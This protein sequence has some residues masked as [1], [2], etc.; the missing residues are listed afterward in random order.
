M[1]E[2]SPNHGQMTIIELQAIDPSPYQLRK[3]FDEDKLKE[4]AASILRDG[5]IEPIVVRP[6][7]ER[8]Q[9]K[10]LSAIET[11]EAIVEIV[12]AELIED[13]EYLSMGDKPAD[14]VKKLLGKIDSVRRSR[15]RGFNPAKETKQAS[16]RFAGRVEDLFNNLPKPLEWRTFYRHDLPLP[17]DFCEEVREVS[18]R[19]RLN[20][21]QTRALEKLRSASIQEFQRVTADAQR[22]APSPVFF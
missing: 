21:S 2:E 22:P 13:K 8:Y 17:I 18:I 4:L 14:R 15:E 12:D 10:N 19:Q 5:L 7:G 6:N 1:P 20:R 3:Y 16:S 11:I 9:Q